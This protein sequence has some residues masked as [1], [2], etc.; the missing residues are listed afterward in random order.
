LRLGVSYDPTKHYDSVRNKWIG[1]DAP[2]P[3]PVN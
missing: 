2:N 3:D 1:L